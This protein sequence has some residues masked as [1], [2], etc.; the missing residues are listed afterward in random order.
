MD[1]AHDNLASGRSFR[2]LNIMDAWSREALAIEADTSLPGKRVVRVLELLVA[3]RRKPKTIQVDNGPEFRGTALDQWAYKN[4]VLLHF[5]EPGKPTQNGHIE[6]FNGK[7]RDECLNQEWFPT[8]VHAR[9]TLK[10]WKH[11]YNWVR[12][13]SALDHQP[14]ALW[15]QQQTQLS[16]FG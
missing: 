6:S 1:F 11:D 5:I 9:C 16:T 14:P 7:L 13:H 15:A 8:L 3:R 10:A 12:P 4:G 2:T